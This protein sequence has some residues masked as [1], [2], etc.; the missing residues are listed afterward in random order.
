M[1]VGL[2]RHLLNLVIAAS[3]LAKSKEISL[4]TQS[5][6]SRH[7]VTP[8]T[9]ISSAQSIGQGTQTNSLRKPESQPKHPNPI[10]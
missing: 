10:F 8:M 6:V 7:N 9:S 2:T 3:P 5:L 1:P 4:Q